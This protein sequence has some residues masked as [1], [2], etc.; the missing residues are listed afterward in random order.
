MINV[1]F[2]V[3]QEF[4]SHSNFVKTLKFELF[5]YEHKGRALRKRMKDITPEQEATSLEELRKEVDQELESIT[6]ERGRELLQEVRVF[7]LP[8]WDI[9][10]TIVFDNFKKRGD[11]TL[12]LTEEASD[13]MYSS[14]GYNPDERTLL[15]WELYPQD[16]RPTIINNPSQVFGNLMVHIVGDINPIE[17]IELNINVA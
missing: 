3:G 14:S 5:F 1:R 16:K 6:P 13:K 7:L 4:V 10:S 17:T 8:R 12:H 11:K 9:S 2:R 15:I